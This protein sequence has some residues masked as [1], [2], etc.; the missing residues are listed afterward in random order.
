MDMLQHISLGVYYP[1]TSPL[2]RLRARTKLLVLLWLIVYL[3][4]A[5]QRRDHYAPYAV[6]VGLLALAVAGSGIGLG[7]LWRRI[8][9]LALLAVLGAI[10]LLLFVVGQPLATLGPYPATYE[11]ARWTMLAYGVVAGA[12]LIGPGLARPWRQHRGRRRRWTRPLRTLLVISLV[13]LAAVWWLTRHMA[14]G[15]T[16]PLGPVVITHEGV[17][18]VVSASMILVVFYALALLLTMTTTPIALVEGL[19][20]L[21]APLRRVG[22]P[23]DDFAL[24][25]LISLRFIPT[26]FDEAEQLTKA[27]T[28]RGADVSR[29]TLR[30]RLQSME[31]W[32]VPLMQ[33]T[34]RRAG[35]LAT[36][37]EARGYEVR[38]ERTAL[39]EGALGA[40]DWLV[41]CGVL[42]VTLAAI[43]P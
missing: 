37:L 17:W 28:A 16:F 6:V 5:N 27:Q 35:E 23:V 10:P 32:F 18:I 21:L 43:L 11:Q 30:E 14:A 26:L 22:A 20:R 15:A 24:M 1:G 42:V 2:H 31:T 4:V 8:R 40:L 7:H 19:T 41:L 13:V 3:L 33:G 9:L 38:G 36:A 34:L 12:Y 29:G 25:L 39:H